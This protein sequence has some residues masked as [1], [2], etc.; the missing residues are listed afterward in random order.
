MCENIKVFVWRLIFTPYYR[1]KYAF[2]YL[3]RKNLQI[4][5]SEK[6]VS[7]IIKNHCSVARLG[8]GE[9]QMITHYM[10]NGTVENFHVDSFQNYSLHLAERLLEV[11]KSDGK[12]ILIC[13][14]YAFRK[15]SVY[16]GYGRTFF[17]REWLLRK[18]LVTPI[19]G[20]RLLGDS[21]FT[22]FYLGRK[23]IKNKKRYVSLLKKIWEGKQILIVE[24]EQSRLGV[25]NDLFDNVAVISRILCPIVNAFDKY[26]CILELVDCCS[27][28]KLVIL[29][30]G[31][32]ATILAFDLSKRGYQAI[33][34]GHL[35]IEYEWMRMKATKKVPIKDKYV[36]EIHK[37][38][39]ST[40]MQDA[41]YQSQI[42]GRVL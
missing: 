10:Q 41:L 21:C 34:L 17:E 15:S 13:I 33:D 24:G 2:T 30:L 27:K 9:F 22:R 40:E 12:D 36:N 28:E 20:L 26:E 16:R 31:H 39:I 32:T 14:P 18:K 1:I 35:D 19:V 37:G 7:Y 5:D 3:E 23:D 25:G 4:L 6:T 42:I 38:R 8:D 11:L 29:A